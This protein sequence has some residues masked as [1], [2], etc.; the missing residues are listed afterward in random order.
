MRHEKREVFAL[1]GRVSDMSFQGSQ[2]SYPVS[3]IEPERIVP[4]QLP[5]IVIHRVHDTSSPNPH[6]HGFSCVQTLQLF[7]APDGCDDLDR[8]VKKCQPSMRRRG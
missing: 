3:L 6:D 5:T 1:H 7:K 2:P 4:N 8:S